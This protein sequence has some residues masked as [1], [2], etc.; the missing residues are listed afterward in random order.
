[1]IDRA[2]RARRPGGIGASAPGSRHRGA[3]LAAAFLVLACGLPRA[4]HALNGLNAI[5]FGVESIGMGG[6]DL[7]VARDALALST[8][9]AGLAR[10]PGLQLDLDA[11]VVR[12]LGIEH[13][14]R[15][16]PPAGI[17]NK[18]V[19]L[20]NLGL[21]GRL[22]R[23]PV[24]LG[25]SLTATG[26]AGY[27]YGRM[28][29]AFGT[30]DRLSS[31][32]GVVRGSLGGAVELTERLAVGASLGLSYARLDQE[33]FPNTS[34]ANPANPAQSFLGLEV[35]NAQGYGTGLRLGALWRLTDRLTLGA[36]YGSKVDLPLR[37]GRVDVDETA[38]GRGQV[39]YDGLKLEGLAQ[40]QELGIGVA[41]QA[42]PK[43]L[44]AADLTWLDWSE[45][46]QT[47]SLR[48]SD[49]D[50]PGAPPVL[51]IASTQDW[52]D[53]YVIAL[54]TAYQPGEA[55]TLWAGYNYGRNPVPNRHL[56]PLLANIYEHHLTA[57]AAWRPREDV[58]LGLA[59]EYL[60]PNEVTY[61]N[62]ELPFGQGAR[63][64]VAYAALHLGLSWQF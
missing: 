57:G 61:D 40:A 35:E 55:V 52:R 17:E 3:R 54:G 30:E 31:L 15:F 21:A 43:L 28:D 20:A 24:S 60:V 58:R 37:D 5:G 26:G 47:T 1:M 38:L 23:L 62:P 63:A 7:A 18:N 11:G 9:P 29:T 44:L 16:G 53:Q 14:D 50:S 34:V 51:R 49:P 4:A 59:V 64:R 33:I 10:L 48:A 12:D 39:R 8:N 19:P 42:T 45:A 41:W 46:L 25:M 36:A 6:A 56:G 27:D 32:L 22:E 2:H 13:D